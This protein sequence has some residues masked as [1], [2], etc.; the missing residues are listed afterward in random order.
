VGDDSSGDSTYLVGLWYQPVHRPPLTVVRHPENLGYGGNQK[1]GYQYAMDHGWD[2]VVLLHGD[3]QYA[4]EMLA[5]WSHP[6]RKARRGG[7]RLAH[8]EAG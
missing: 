8:H 4:P 6:S 7:V 5:R 3:G 1:W 2:I